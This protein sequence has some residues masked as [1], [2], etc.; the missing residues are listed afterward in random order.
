MEIA[1][2]FFTTAGV[3][4][5]HQPLSYRLRQTVPKW[6]HDRE[7]KASQNLRR[8]MMK[9]HR[10]IFLAGP[11]EADG[12]KDSQR[13]RSRPHRASFEDG[14]QCKAPQGRWNAGI[15]TL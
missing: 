13:A 1:Q 9:Q 10:G 4:I 14:S 15:I 12:Q 3:Q 6:I 2:D 11:Y 7:G 8:P 5:G